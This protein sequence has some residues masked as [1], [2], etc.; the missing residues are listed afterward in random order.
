MVAFHHL[1]LPSFK[2]AIHKVPSQFEVAILKEDTVSQ[3]LGSGHG[4]SDELPPEFVPSAGARHA[5]VRRANKLEGWS[6]GCYGNSN[7]A[8]LGHGT[9][10]VRNDNGRK[11]DNEFLQWHGTMSAVSLH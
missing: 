6:A 7:R 9:R 11:F 3:C 1:P 5:E 8:G 4:N 2:V 10:G